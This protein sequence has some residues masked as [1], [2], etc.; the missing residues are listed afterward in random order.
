MAV[1]PV[2]FQR[3]L[4]MV[5]FRRRQGAEAQCHAALMT[6]RW[7]DGFICPKCGET[8]HFTFER[9]GLTYWQCS[10]CR[11]QTSVLGRT[12]FGAAKPPLT[13]WFLGM[14]LLTRSKNNVSAL[15]LKRGLEVRYDMAWRLKHKLMQVMCERE[16]LRPLSGMDDAC[17]GGERPG[18]NRGRGSEN[19]VSFAAA[20]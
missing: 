13:K 16:A 17:L 9:D 8:H 2:Q 1:N 10:A 11:K 14:P 20:V 18:G 7:P 5:D 12:I 19:K 15:A 3:G 4:S 6:V